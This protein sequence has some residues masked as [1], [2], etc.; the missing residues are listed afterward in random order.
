VDREKTC[1]LLLRVFVKEGQHHAVQEYKGALPAEDELQMYTWHDATLRELAE[2]IQEVRPEA[3]GG[4]VRL[5]FSFVYPD[6]KGNNV[7]RRVGA[8]HGAKPGPD[9]HKTLHLL[10][11]QTGDYLDVAIM[12]A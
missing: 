11:F 7:M 10:S 4:R 2:L 8:V 1:P 9:D 6:H 12:K 5:T 3:K